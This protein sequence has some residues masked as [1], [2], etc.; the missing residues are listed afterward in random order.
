MLH[1]R[2]DQAIIPIAS[3]MLSLKDICRHFGRQRTRDVLVS[4]DQREELP[5]NTRQ[6]VDDLLY[7]GLANETEAGVTLTV[8]GEQALRSFDAELV[9]A[10]LAA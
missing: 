8:A 3:P 1:D 10:T 5:P 2:S 6:I 4:I 7:I 9:S